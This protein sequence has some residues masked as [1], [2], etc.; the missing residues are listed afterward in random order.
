MCH[1]R[2]WSFVTSGH[3]KNF[4]KRKILYD[5]E[6]FLVNFIHCMSRFD[7]KPLISFLKTWAKNLGLA[8]NLVFLKKNMV[9]QF[10]FRKWQNPKSDKNLWF[11]FF[12]LIFF[13]GSEEPPATNGW[14]QFRVLTSFKLLHWKG[15]YSSN[16]PEVTQ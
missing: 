7:N 12:W 16:V 9:V 10:F 4:P 6:V 1:F 11:R 15:F 2:N 14:A 8:E 3:L 13:C 5:Y